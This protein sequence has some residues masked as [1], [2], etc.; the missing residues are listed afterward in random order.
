MFQAPL[1]DQPRT[2]ELSKLLPYSSIAYD[3]PIPLRFVVSENVDITTSGSINAIRFVTQNVIAIDIK[4]ERAITWPNQC[5]VLPLHSPIQVNEGDTIAM[6]F[7]YDAGDSIESLCKT[8]SC[9]RKLRPTAHTRSEASGC[10]VQDNASGMMHRPH[11]SR[12]VA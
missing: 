12:T 1:L 8:L 10:L 7:R 3:A 4:A 11:V 9:D 2:Q 5:L 6:S